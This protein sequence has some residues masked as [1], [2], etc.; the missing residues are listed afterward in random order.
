MPR[1]ANQ[2]IILNLIQI[3]STRGGDRDDGAWIWKT[4]HMIPN[5]LGRGGCPHW[6]AVTECLGFPLKVVPCPRRIEPRPLGA[7]NISSYRLLHV[8]SMVLIGQLSCFPIGWLVIIQN[9]YF[10]RHVSLYRHL[11]RTEIFHVEILHLW[12]AW[13]SHSFLCIWL[14]DYFFQH[15]PSITNL[16]CKRKCTQ[17]DLQRCRLTWH[18]QNEHA[19]LTL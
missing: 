1:H 2:I 7:D 8:T 19:N 6:K 11:L 14:D 9:P 16:L 10:V 15:D 17:S 4:F 13:H 3:N 12:T 18:A 5:N